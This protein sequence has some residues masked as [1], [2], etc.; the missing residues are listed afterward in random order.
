[1]FTT[2]ACGTT[3]IKNKSKLGKEDENAYIS[4][5]TQYVDQLVSER[6]KIKNE[7]NNPSSSLNA[8]IATPQS[9]SESISL[10]KDCQNAIYYDINYDAAEFMRRAK[11][12]AGDFGYGGINLYVIDLK[13]DAKFL[14]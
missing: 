14:R 1:L 9:C 11:D 13:D 8:I 6:E 2:D 12:S 7:F 4:L 10:H 3:L 5:R